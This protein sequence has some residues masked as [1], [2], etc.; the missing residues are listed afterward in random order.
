MFARKMIVGLIILAGVSGCSLPL[1]ITSNPVDVT[2]ASPA[3]T[4]G[5]VAYDP[6]EIR[7]HGTINGERAELSNVVCH[8]HGSGFSAE[9]FTPALVNMPDYGARSRPV[10]VR[11]RH[12]GVQKTVHAMPYNVTTERETGN[13]LIWSNKDGLSAAI[14]IDLS[15]KPDDWSYRSIYVWF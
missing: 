10:A 4:R 8:L 1:D 2:F 15:N 11:C 7:A 5:I 3:Y 9:I 12:N 14:H 6:V 13:E